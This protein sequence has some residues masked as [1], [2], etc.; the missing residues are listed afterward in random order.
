ML[1]YLT[2]STKATIEIPSDADG[3]NTVK[4]IDLLSNNIDIENHKITD[5]SIIE[6]TEDY[7]ARPDLISLAVY[8]SDQY[9]DAICK[10]NGI[11]NPFELNKGMV[12]FIPDFS[13]ISNMY[14]KAT[15]SSVCSNDSDNIS[16]T[17]KNNQKSINSKRSPNE[18]TIG[19]T[20]F[21][22]DKQNKLVIY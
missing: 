13:A 6:V 4:C 19:E 7:I 16:A 11:S 9:A 2:L 8:G 1:N 14:I 10:I 17:K 3:T 15:T 5:C 20:N 21:I 18:Q 12:L 22:I